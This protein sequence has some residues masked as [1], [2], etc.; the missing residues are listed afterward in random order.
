MQTKIFGQHDEQTMRQF[1]MCLDYG[2]VA[3]G[4]L[5]ADGHYGYS[6]PVG[7]VIVY[8]NHLLEWAMILRVEIKQ[9]EQI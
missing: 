7:G 5:C 8:E 4:V 2:N 3:G 9:L 1:N 6:Q